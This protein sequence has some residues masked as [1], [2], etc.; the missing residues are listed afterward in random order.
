M[1]SL[2]IPKQVT[3]ITQRELVETYNLANSLNRLRQNYDP[4]WQRAL[5]HA[6]GM[7]GVGSSAIRQKIREAL[8]LP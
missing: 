4:S 8:E 7:S 3:E 5:Y 2:K 1:A 6:L